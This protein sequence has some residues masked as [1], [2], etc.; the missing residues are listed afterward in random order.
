MEGREPG[1][2][3]MSPYANSAIRVYLNLKMITITCIN[4]LK[5]TTATYAANLI[6]KSE[7]QTSGHD[8]SNDFF[9]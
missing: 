9:L 8:F 5:N 4:F 3:R 7:I 2:S 6:D 1:F